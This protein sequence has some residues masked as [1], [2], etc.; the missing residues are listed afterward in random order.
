LV[1]TAKDAVKLK[2][3]EFTIPCYVAMAETV[4]DDP[5]VFRELVISS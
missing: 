3:L 5:A 1:T 4:I 2:G